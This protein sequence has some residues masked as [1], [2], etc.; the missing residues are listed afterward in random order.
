MQAR[1]NRPRATQWRGAGVAVLQ[2]KEVRGLRLD[3]DE[4][5]AFVIIDTARVE[6]P[7]HASLYAADPNRGPAHARRL[8]AY[9]M[10]LLHQRVSVQ[11]A[12]LGCHPL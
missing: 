6:N 1:L 4:T 7:G 11:E 9:L 2:A 10:P 3:G 12:Y 5:Q 8:R